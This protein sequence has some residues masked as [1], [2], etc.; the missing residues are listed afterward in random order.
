METLYSFAMLVSSGE[1]PK[2]GADL[3]AKILRPVEPVLPN[4][5]LSTPEKRIKDWLDRSLHDVTVA[6]VV[7]QFSKVPYGWSDYATIYYLNELVR[8]HLYAFNYNNNPNVSREETARNIV[9]DASKFTVEKAKAISQEVL[10]DFIDA[11]KHIFNVMSVKGSNDST[12]LFRNCKE[13]DDSQLNTLLKNYRS[14]SHKLS[15]CPFVHTIDEAVTL[16]ENWLTERDHLKFFQTIIDARDEACRLFDRC[17]S[18]NSFHNDQFPNY[19]KV[20]KFIDDNR[21]NFD[22]LTD[23]QQPTVVAIRAI[24]TDE[25]PWDKMPSYMKMMR[26]LNGQLG[27]CKTRLI[28]KIKSNYNKV[29]DELEQY[30][31]EVNVSR[32]KFAKRDITISLKTSTSNFYALQA[33]ADTREFLEEEMKKINSAI[34]VSPSEQRKR[35]IVHL[36]THTTKPMRSEADVDIY[37]A[38]LKAEL[39]QYI[40]DNN[41]IIIG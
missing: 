39:M 33:N 36:N 5:P 41:D 3:S 38:G 30:A 40:N 7:R 20:R 26:T 16:M 28:E 29:F 19:E 13:T 2:N 9:R 12:E 17:K 34:S 21:D 15:G 22:F 10:N 35:K 6:D 8:H 14:L 4:M 11:W 25:E 37:L 32:E 23:E 31:N 24:F 27:E 1:T 18:I